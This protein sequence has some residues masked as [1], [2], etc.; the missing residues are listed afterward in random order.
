MPRPPEITSARLRP[1]RAQRS[2]RGD[3]QGGTVADLLAWFLQGHMIEHA[4]D[5]K[6]PLD[7]R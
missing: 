5:L 6:Q 2:L 7:L 3:P 4:R 1:P